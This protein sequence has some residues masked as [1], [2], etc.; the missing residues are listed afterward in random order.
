[1]NAV[2]SVDDADSLYMASFDVENLFTNVPLL[3][4]IDICVDRL[5]HS[6]SVVCGIPRKFFVTLLSNAVLN[7]FFI[8]AG[9]LYK[10][11]DG[12]GM[13]LPL[14]PTFANVF[15]CHHENIWLDECPADF[16]PVFYKRYIDDTF[17]LFRHPSHSDLFLDYLN[18]KHPNIKFTCEVEQSNQLPFLDCNITRV[19]NKFQSSVFR[20][21]TFTGLGISFFSFCTH[22]FK[23]NAIKTLIHRAYRNCSTYFALHQEFE[24]LKSFFSNNGFP[25]GLFYHHLNSFMS[26]KFSYLAPVTTV[27]KR[28]LYVTL[29]Y[30]GSQSDKLKRELSSLLSNFFYNTEFHI[31]L[32]NK[33]SIGSFFNFKDKLPKLMQSSLIY[34]YCCGKCPSE[35][36]GLTSRTL[37]QRVAE[38]CGRSFRTGQWLAKPPYSSIRL[39]AEE[40]DS[41][42]SIDNFTILSNASNSLDLRFLESLYIFKLKP[43]L[44]DSQSSIPLTVV[45]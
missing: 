11:I 7:S 23:A 19:N 9:K 25:T 35:Y 39:H 6:C 4:T 42:I 15:M 21:S 37:H 20:K 17:L 34:K 30:F 16:R 38:H 45:N 44:N 32:V 41:R 29:P 8:F 3:E 18:N 26:S 1:M 36:V 24:F 33:F 22:K 13:G 40:C 12:I 28:Q 14:G 10:Q 27:K 5:F 2:S 31:I 43:N